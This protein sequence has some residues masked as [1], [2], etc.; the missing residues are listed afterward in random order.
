[1]TSKSEDRAAHELTEAMEETMQRVQGRFQTL[2]HQLEDKN[3][4]M[5][6]RIDDLQKN[7]SELMT[8]AGMDQA[9]C[10]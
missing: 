5:G 7:V 1:M 6:R 8:Q 10:K 3:I 4:Q 2:S 9:V